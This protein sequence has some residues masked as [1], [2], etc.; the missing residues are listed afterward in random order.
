MKIPGYIYTIQKKDAGKGSAELP[1]CQSCGNK[2]SVYWSSAI[3]VAQATD[4]GKKVY[5]VQSDDPKED[6]IIIQVES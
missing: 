6:R 3:G 2:K 5:G 1:S 4:I